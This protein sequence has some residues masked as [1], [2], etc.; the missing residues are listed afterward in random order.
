MTKMC[1]ECRDVFALIPWIVCLKNK[2]SV[3]NEATEKSILS[4]FRPLFLCSQCTFHGYNNAI[5]FTFLFWK[6]KVWSWPKINK[7]ETAIA[8]NKLSMFHTE[9]KKISPLFGQVIISIIIVDLLY[10]HLI[11]N[12]L[13]PPHVWNFSSSPRE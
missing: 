3:K 11:L 7:Y 1:Q 13:L 10:R 5:I 4:N 12:T 6:K 9:R 2:S 8:Q